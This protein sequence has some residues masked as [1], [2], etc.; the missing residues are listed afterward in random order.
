MKNRKC[1]TGNGKQKCPCFILNFVFPVSCFALI[2]IAGSEVR[3]NELFLDPRRTGLR[4]HH[5]LNWRVAMS[6][7]RHRAVWMSALLLLALGASLLVAALVRDHLFHSARQE[8]A[9]G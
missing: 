1:K 2:S 3:R 6:F 4:N 7:L 8:S 9:L 5:E